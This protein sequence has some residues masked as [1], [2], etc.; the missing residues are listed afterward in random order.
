MHTRAQKTT[1]GQRKCSA[2]SPDSRSHTPFPPPPPLSIS[3]QSHL[4][5]GRSQ[6]VAASVH[7]T[8]K[9]KRPPLRLSQSGRERVIVGSG[10]EHERGGGQLQRACGQR[11]DGRSAKENENNTNDTT[12]LHDNRTRITTQRTRGTKKASGKKHRS[13]HHTFHSVHRQDKHT[14]VALPNGTFG[15]IFCGRREQR[16]FARRGG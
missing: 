5:S 13:A 12:T 6:H 7:T 8:Q 3:S 16:Q 15:N 9:R 10:R 1:E 2:E 11:A 14:F 4:Q